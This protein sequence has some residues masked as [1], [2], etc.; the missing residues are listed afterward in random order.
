MRESL[1]C[2]GRFPLLSKL[3]FRLVQSLRYG[4]ESMVEGAAVLAV[5]TTE[6]MRT[7]PSVPERRYMVE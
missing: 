5:T 6:D 2:L 3:I 1:Y 4:C 7:A